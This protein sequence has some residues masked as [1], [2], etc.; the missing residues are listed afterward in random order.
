MVSYNLFVRAIE[1]MADSERRSKWSAE[2]L[3]VMD[4]R[5]C[6]QLAGK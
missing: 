2:W 5:L 3:E 6:C 1:V 4:G